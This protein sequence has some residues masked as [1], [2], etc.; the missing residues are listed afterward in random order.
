M[1]ESF[2]N[3]P[4]PGP[5]VNLLRNIDLLSTKKVQ[6]TFYIVVKMAVAIK[7]LARKSVTTQK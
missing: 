1:A 6:K 5:R 4:P 2:V 7:E 3:P